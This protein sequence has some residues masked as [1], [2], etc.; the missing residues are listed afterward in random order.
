[1]CAHS[2]G[3]EFRSYGQRLAQREYRA[4]GMSQDPVNGA[5]A[6]Q[7][8]KCGALGGAQNDETRLA[9]SCFCQN[10]D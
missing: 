5:V 8:F 6:R 3:L 7:I 1:M 2:F 4:P 9:G 10:L